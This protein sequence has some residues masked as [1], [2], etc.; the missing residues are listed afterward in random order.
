[1]G[2][3]TEDRAEI[4]RRLPRPRTPFVPAPAPPV[5]FDP[6]GTDDIPDA[7]SYESPPGSFELGFSAADPANLP[8]G[9]SFF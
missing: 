9:I 8:G 7:K 1:M 6:K 3:F 5:A 2:V 4:G